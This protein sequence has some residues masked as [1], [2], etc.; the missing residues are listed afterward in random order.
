MYNF[1]RAI[2]AVVWSIVLFVFRLDRSDAVAPIKTIKLKYDENN[3]PNGEKKSTKKTVHFIRHA[4]GLHNVAGEKNYFAYQSQEFYDCA[5]SAHGE[6]QCAAQRERFQ[7]LLRTAQLVV[8]SPLQRTLQ[9][10][11]LALPFLE[12]VVPWVAIESIRETTGLHPC[13]KRRS[14][15][16]KM[17]QPEFKHI[18]FSFIESD[19]DAL[20]D[21]YSIREPEAHVARRAQNFFDWLETRKES[22]VVVVTHSAFLRTLFHQIILECDDDDKKNY[23]N[24]EIRSYIIEIPLRHRKQS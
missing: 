21:L 17:T 16:E 14:R 7:R 6:Q 8:I 23:E 18:D 10:A 12:G 24:C 11:C 22:E 4:E 9:T 5:L 15:S 3:T 13:D 1:L 20:Y 19:F 2:F